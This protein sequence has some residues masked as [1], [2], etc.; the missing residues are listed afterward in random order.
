[1]TSELD[2]SSIWSANDVQILDIDVN[3]T[4]I[5]QRAR[6]L[7]RQGARRRIALPQVP[8]S[9]VANRRPKRD[10]KPPLG[11]KKLKISLDIFNDRRNEFVCTL[12]YCQSRSLM[13][14]VCPQRGG[15]IMHLDN[16][17][18]MAA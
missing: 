9:R 7:V 8:P 3:R 11:G 15:K 16:Y 2:M 6:G 17:S 1:M 14:T 5:M 13:Q 18:G 4:F 12:N 10:F